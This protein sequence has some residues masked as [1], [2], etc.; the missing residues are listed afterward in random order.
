MSLVNPINVTSILSEK[1]LQGFPNPEEMH[2]EFTPLIFPS[3]PL[4]QFDTSGDKGT[5]NQTD[6]WGCVKDLCPRSRNTHTP[7][8]PR[9]L[10]S[11]GSNPKSTG[12]VS[13][14]SSGLEMCVQTA[15]LPGGH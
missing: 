12:H 9:H 6:L 15:Q 11:R 8:L 14:V 7:I 10:G 2:F 1:A 3:A 13:W 4:E 5:R